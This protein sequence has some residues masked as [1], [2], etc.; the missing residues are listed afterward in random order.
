MKLLHAR[1]ET[2][3]LQRAFE[4]A[5]CKI[6]TG[7]S[8][9]S[10]LRESLYSIYTHT[11]LLGVGRNDAGDGRGGTE[12]GHGWVAL[13][14]CVGV[15]GG[16]EKV[17]RMSL[18]RATASEGSPLLGL[19]PRHTELEANCAWRQQIRLKEK[20]VGYRTSQPCTR[21]RMAKQKA[22]G[23]SHVYFTRG[24]GVRPSREN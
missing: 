12:H 24:L 21:T 5:P 7:W 17:R 8:S 13:W 15:V 3:S 4:S 10:F 9:R 23:H 22:T 2:W 11:Y 1:A 19:P 20:L 16:G 6:G 18:H 14:C